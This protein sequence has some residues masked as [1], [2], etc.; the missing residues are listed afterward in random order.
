MSIKII[1][2]N[3]KARFNYQILEKYEAGL[4]LTGTE[5]KSL[6]RG[7]V[8]LKDSYVV[9]QGDE[10]YLKNAHISEYRAGSYNNHSPER[11]RKILLH[12]REMNKLMGKIQEKNLACIPLK[13]YF[14]A[15]KAKVEIGVG[16]G[17][18]IHDKRQS[19]KKKELDRQMS[20]ALKGQK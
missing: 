20:R 2:E 13:L 1:T 12:R 11:P 4:V 19:L 14:K 15:G 8:N 18:K 7:S 17:K 16:R 3:K 5:V 6:R 10:A 9:F